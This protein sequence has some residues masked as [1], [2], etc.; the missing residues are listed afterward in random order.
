M[1]LISFIQ[2]L[3]SIRIL[4]I[5]QPKNYTPN[6]YQSPKNCIHPIPVKQLINVRDLIPVIHPIID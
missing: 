2:L 1:D 3:T 4:D 6:N 5:I